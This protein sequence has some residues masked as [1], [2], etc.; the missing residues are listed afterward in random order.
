MENGSIIKLTVKVL[1]NTRLEINIQEPGLTKEQMVL[2]Y[3][4]QQVVQSIEVTGRM[5]CSMVT[6]L[7]RCK[8]EQNTR[9]T[10][11]LV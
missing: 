6:A 8:M 2:E 4:R 9:V 5:T 10:L 7:K 3:I 11:E 1:S